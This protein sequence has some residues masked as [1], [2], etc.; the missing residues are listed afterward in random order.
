MNPVGVGSD[1]KIHGI[2]QFRGGLDSLTHTVGFLSLLVCLTDIVTPVGCWVVIGT[3][4]SSIITV[5]WGLYLVEV[6]TL[7]ALSL[8]C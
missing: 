6:G 3:G 5:E 8:S 2:P 4:G 1:P 7:F